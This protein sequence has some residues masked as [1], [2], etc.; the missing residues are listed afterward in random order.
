MPERPASRPYRR[1]GEVRWQ[2][3][4]LR[5]DLLK[6]VYRYKTLLGTD[7]TPAA[8]AAMGVLEL[9]P[10]TYPFHEHPAPEIYYVLRG[11][12]T[13][14]VGEKTFTARE[15]TAIYHA[16]GA[17]HRMVNRTQEPLLAVWFWWAPGGDLAV[18]REPSRIIG[19][20]ST[21]SRGRREK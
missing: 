14:T 6:D 10:G 3:D 12:A 13:W 16:P 7:N 2:W 19:D 17:R 9:T 20:T 21:P 18:L 4:D 8:G 15:G 11:R 1:A 5:P